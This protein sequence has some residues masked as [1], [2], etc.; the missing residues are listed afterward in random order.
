MVLDF[1]YRGEVTVAQE[2]L[3]TVQ[4]LSS[5]RNGGT[6]VLH[7]MRPQARLSPSL[8]SRGVANPA[9][10]YDMVSAAL[11]CTLLVLLLVLAMSG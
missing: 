5:S 6:L 11:L 10:R 3:N 8:I 2:D 9:W 1:I 4:F 7:P